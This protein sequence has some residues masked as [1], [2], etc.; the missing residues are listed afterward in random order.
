MNSANN[1]LPKINS[2]KIIESGL[3]F[4]ILLNII[5]IWQNE[6]LFIYC[7]SFIALLLII[8][9][10]LL[11]PLAY[12]WFLTSN[13]LRYISTNLILA[14]VFIL[15]ITPMGIIRR[16]YKNYDKKR[17]KNKNSKSYFIHIDKRITA[18]DLINP[19]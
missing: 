4:I 19:Y 5:G 17:L 13:L 6:M 18:N 14:I 15:L 8:F 2:K 11:F 7:A 3:I 12:L 16:L 10:N 9:P 1:I